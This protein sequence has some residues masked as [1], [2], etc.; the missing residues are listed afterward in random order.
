MCREKPFGTLSLGTETYFVKP[1]D[2]CSGITS[3]AMGLLGDYSRQARAY[4]S[5]RT[6]SPSVLAPLR[7]ALAGAPGRE[8]VDIGGGTGNY[9]LAL[10]QEGWRPLVVDRSAQMLARAA[11]KGLD[12]VR[13]NA[14]RL[15]FADASFDAAMLVSMLHHV[16]TPARALAEAKRVL[17]PGGRLALM[18]FTREDI[19]DAWC[20]DYFPSSRAWM[21]E[22]HMPLAQLLDALPGAQRIPVVYSDLRDGSMAAMLAHPELLLDPARRAQTSYFERMQRDHADELAA[23]LDRLERELRAGD[24][25]APTRAGHASILAWQKPTTL[26]ANG[27]ADGA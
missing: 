14:T 20:L 26:T 1:L 21:H 11:A 25:S 6:A 12:T 9:A 4:D 27:D 13:A 15:P 17:R 22:T 3:I 16:D 8:L 5:T 2:E 19:A 18:V 7:R 10:S 23:G 24:G